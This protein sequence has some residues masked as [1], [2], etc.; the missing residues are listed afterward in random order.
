MDNNVALA[1]LNASLAM[2][3]D[4]TYA[5]TNMLI[6]PPTARLASKATNLKMEFVSEF[7]AW[8][9]VLIAL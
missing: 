9:N 7:H 4:A 3:M 5:K 2:K 8:L 6:S 1:L